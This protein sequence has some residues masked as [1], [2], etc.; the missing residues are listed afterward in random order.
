MIMKNFSFLFIVMIE[1]AIGYALITPI[2][3]SLAMQRG[4]TESFIGIVFS[5][6]PIASIIVIPFIPY[7]IKKFGRI[8]LLYFSLVLEVNIYK[9]FQNL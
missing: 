4:L 6:F 8:N 9:N 1:S 7:L 3:P 2:Y 5:C